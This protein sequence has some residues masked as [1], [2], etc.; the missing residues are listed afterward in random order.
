MFL[1]MFFKTQNIGHTMHLTMLGK[2]L[3]I[4]SA[5]QMENS[6]HKASVCLRGVG[7]KRYL[8]EFHL[9]SISLRKGLPLF[10]HPYAQ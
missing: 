1:T 5:V 7:V 6:S 10:A 2:P 4:R 8:A 3:S 9:N